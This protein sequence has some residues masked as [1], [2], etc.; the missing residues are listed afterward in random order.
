MSRGGTKACCDQIHSQRRCADSRW[1]AA[2][3]RRGLE[4][5]AAR[6]DG[7][8]DKEIVFLRDRV[9]ELQSQ[10][11]ILRQLHKPDNTTRYTFRPIL[12]G[13]W[14]NTCTIDRFR[15]GCRGKLGL[16]ARCNLVSYL[17]VLH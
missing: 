17:F 1:V 16:L 5:V 12:T 3:R 2:S 7:D 4:V 13:L 9:A 15:Y 6:P 8:K 11:D 10:V 14:R